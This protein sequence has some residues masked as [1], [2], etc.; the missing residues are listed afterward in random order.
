[1]Y[2]INK[3]FVKLK[4]N[5]YFDGSKKGFTILCLQYYFRSDAKLY[6][7]SSHIH[8]VYN[9]QSIES[10]SQ[11]DMLLAI[12]RAWIKYENE[13]HLMNYSSSFPKV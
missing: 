12:S 2:L 7:F 11:K 3:Q 9:I 8:L 4:I 10:N 6:I 13:K 5:K 1:M